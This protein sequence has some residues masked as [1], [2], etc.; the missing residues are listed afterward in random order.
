MKISTSILSIKDNFKENV[1]KLFNTNTDYLHLDIMDGVFVEQKTWDSKDLEFIKDLNKPLD[2]HLMVSDI[3]K[4]IDEFA[5]Y[6]PEYITIHYEAT[7]DLYLAIDYIKSYGIKVGVS[8]KP[9]TDI[10]VL[11]PF[12]NLVDLILIMSVEPGKG[13]QSFIDKTKKKINSLNFI[14]ERGKYRFKIEVDG[15]INDTNIKDIKA[16]IVVV[17]S[18]ITSTNNYQEQIDKLR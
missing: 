2:V 17:G 6:N 1:I 15:G 7:N 16:D 5:S 4:Y 12:F 13:G 3:Y 8:I 11:K 9:D 10:S 14:K 18:Y